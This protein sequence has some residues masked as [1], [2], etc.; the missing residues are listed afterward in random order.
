MLYS[1]PIHPRPSRPCLLP[2]KN[3]RNSSDYLTEAIEVSTT[4]LDN[5]RALKSGGPRDMCAAE[6]RML[7]GEVAKVVIDAGVDYG[8]CQ[9][10]HV[11][12]IVPINNR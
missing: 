8:D 5:N 7:A 10:Q 12:I 11:Y 2:H 3:K 9:P 1:S 6:A 4:R